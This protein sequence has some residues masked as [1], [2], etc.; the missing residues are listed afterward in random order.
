MINVSVKISRD[1]GQWVEDIDRRKRIALNRKIQESL[2][3]VKEKI[4]SYA[5]IESG[6]L[7]TTIL[8]LPTTSIKTRGLS[9]IY[10]TGSIQISVLLGR[11]KDKKIRWVNDG[12]G[13]FGPHRRLIY[14]TKKS[15]MIFKIDGKWIA[16]K[17]TKGQKGQKFI[18][19]GIRASR[20]IISTKILS[21]L[22]S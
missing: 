7:R 10:G 17:R 6:D 22:K 20:L 4:A 8:S 15:L 14:P 16:V 12:T 9:V 13:L 21:A 1:F 5:P 11:R 18:Q 3:Y 2:D 19:R